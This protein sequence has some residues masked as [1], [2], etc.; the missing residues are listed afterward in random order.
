MIEEI[1][2]G[3][4]KYG[5]PTDSINLY[6]YGQARNLTLGQLVNAICCRAG[7]ALETQAVSLVNVMT[8]RTRRLNAAAKVMQT[9]VDGAEKGYDTELELEGYGTV[10]ARK[11]L[12]EEMGYTITVLNND[13]KKTVK[14]Q[15]KLPAEVE[16][17]NG[18]LMIYT[19]MKEKIDTMTTESQRR[20]IDLQSCMSRRDVVFA[21]ATN[22]VQTLGGVLQSVAANY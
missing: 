21:S 8:M 22:I 10:T 7:F 18:R 15:G 11:F 9:L 19:A 1:A 17:P 6:G 5:D 2:I 13:E 3:T 4:N 14:E 16:T 20:M 12:T